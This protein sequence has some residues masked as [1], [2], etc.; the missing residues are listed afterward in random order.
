MKNRFGFPLRGLSGYALPYWVYTVILLSCAFLAFFLHL[1]DQEQARAEQLLSHYL[2]LYSLNGT[3]GLRL[4]HGAMGAGTSFVR[5]EGAGLRFI[6]VTGKGI[7]EISD[8]SETL[9]DFSTFMVS[10][11]LV[12]KDLQ[13]K[14]GWGHWT[15]AAARMNTGRVDTGSGFLQVG[16]DSSESLALLRRIALVFLL[17]TVF[18]MFFSLILALLTARKQSR[19]LRHLTATIA[20]INRETFHE[21]E[22]LDGFEPAEVELVTA[23]NQLIA[24]HHQLSSELSDSMDNVA[25]DLRTPMTRLRAIAEYGLQKRDDN[26]HLSEALADC[27]E[28]SDRLLSMLNTMLNVAEAEAD[29]VNLDLQCVDLAASINGVLEL[30]EITAEEQGVEIRFDV[31]KDETIQILA[32][33]QRISQVWANLLDNSIKYNSSEIVIF[34]R[35]TENMAEIVMQDNGMGISENEI[36]QIWTRLFRG[37]RSRSK[38]GLGLG[39][40]LV[41]AMVNNHNGTISV[42]STLNQGTTFTVSLPLARQ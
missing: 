41:R 39:L 31:G 42:R 13:E 25:H 17:M 2:K 3:A 33:P 35:V 16:I 11:S 21:V 1:R 30:Y 8:G 40:T 38:P 18:F 7:T 24:R 36:K 4:S 14:G 34:S 10:D 22:S 26:T 29:T 19:V 37:D 12:W 15:V 32:D 5:M 28:E 27:L 23:V 20:A 9:P 6:R